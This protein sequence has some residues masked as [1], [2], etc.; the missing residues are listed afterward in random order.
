MVLETEAEFGQTFWIRQYRRHDR[1]G[2]HC[3]TK[4]TYKYEGK[5][6]AKNRKLRMEQ[7]GPS[8]MDWYLLMVSQHGAKEA[9]RMCFRLQVAKSTRHYNTEDRVLP[10]AIFEYQGKRHVLCSQLT[11]G[12]YY[13]VVV[14]GTKNCPSKQ[15]RIL[16][17][18][19]GL[20]FL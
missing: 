11:G 19:T 10:G 17:R 14:G 9:D 3:Q 16:Q 6:V 8:L 13:R 7:K 12:S 15:C 2:I 1:S 4:R 5:T 20:V 18:N